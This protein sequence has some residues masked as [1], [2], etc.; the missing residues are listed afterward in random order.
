MDK[1]PAAH[2]CPRGSRPLSSHR[3]SHSARIRPSPTVIWTSV[4][5]RV[6][7]RCRKTPPGLPNLPA[8]VA[9]LRTAKLLPPLPRESYLL[10]NH[11]RLQ[12]LHR[13]QICRPGCQ[14]EPTNR[15]LH[16]RSPVSWA[17][18]HHSRRILRNNPTDRKLT[19]SHRP[20]LPVLGPRLPRF[21]QWCPGQRQK[22]QTRIPASPV[23]I[24]AHRML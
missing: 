7:P 8:K 22:R 20:F 13:R 21:K 11:K 18:G 14:P 6:P 24:G 2:S 12:S 19:M 4:V 23:K 17:L 15:M 9:G 3:L 1:R 10:F 16:P 5:T